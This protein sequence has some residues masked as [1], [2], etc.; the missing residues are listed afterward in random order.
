MSKNNNLVVDFMKVDSSLKAY[1]H[2]EKNAGYDLYATKNTWIFPFKVKKVPV[3]L[4]CLLPTNTFGLVTSR[5][6][7]SL[8]G[9][10]VV[11]GVIDCNYTGQICAIM[12]R[13]GFLPRRIKKGT[14]I[15]QMIII[16]YNDVSFTE[17]SELSKT[18]RGS[19]GFGSSGLK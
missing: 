5:S 17:K 3:N 2:S 4:C 18:N 11:P 12:T 19:N 13:I 1:K 6:G 8:K 10:F 15:A 9:N 7:E 16:N 14:R